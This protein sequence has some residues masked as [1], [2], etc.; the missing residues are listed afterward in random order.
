MKPVLQKQLRVVSSCLFSSQ[1]NNG[2][3][4]FS[5][6][7]LQKQAAVSR[8][9]CTCFLIFRIHRSLLNDA[10]IKAGCIPSYYWMLNE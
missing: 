1:Q 6:Y 4:Y 5:I 7:V 8:V 9:R 3:M 10:A 2:Y